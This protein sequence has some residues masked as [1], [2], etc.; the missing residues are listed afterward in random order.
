M[1]K[2][3]IALGVG[4]I[5]A[6]VEDYSERL[7][8]QPSLVVPDEYALWRTPA[9]NFSIRKVTDD[10]VGQLRHMGW[11]DPEVHAFTQDVDCNGITWECFSLSQQLDEIA[12]AWPGAIKSHGRV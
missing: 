9:L 7:Q 3:H 12:L 11:E 8:A 5:T 4:D 6:S 10:A 2:L 1:R